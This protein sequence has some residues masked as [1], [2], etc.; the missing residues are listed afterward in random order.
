MIRA[1]QFFSNHHSDDR[2]KADINAGKIFLLVLEVDGKTEKKR[3]REKKTASEMIRK[4]ECIKNNSD[5]DW[6]KQ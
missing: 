4:D 1:V 6:R 5:V 2:I 3:E